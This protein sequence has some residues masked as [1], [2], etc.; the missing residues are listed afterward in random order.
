MVQDQAQNKGISIVQ[1][2]TSS[3][4]HKLQQLATQNE[5]Y[6]EEGESLGCHVECHV[7]YC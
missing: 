2:T 7:Y 4:N 5:S 1:K 6:F 3:K